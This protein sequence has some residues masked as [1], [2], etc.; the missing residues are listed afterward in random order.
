MQRLARAISYDATE[1]VRGLERVRRLLEN[2]GEAGLRQE[3]GERGVPLRTDVSGSKVQQLEVHNTG[4]NDIPPAERLKRDKV[5]INRN[6][7]DVNIQGVEI[8]QP[9]K[10]WDGTRMSREN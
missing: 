4:G 2:C 8:S 9:Q 5:N 7:G 1:T 3:S 6:I 10:P